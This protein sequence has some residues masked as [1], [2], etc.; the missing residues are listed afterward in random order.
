MMWFRVKQRV[1]RMRYHASKA[2][3]RSYR[4]VL[5]LPK[6]QKLDSDYMLVPKE[7]DD[8]PLGRLVD[9]DKLKD[10]ATNYTT[11]Y[12][13]QPRREFYADKLGRFLFYNAAYD[14]PVAILRNIGH[15]FTKFLLRYAK[16][17]KWQSYHYV[18]RQKEDHI[19]GYI[20]FKVGPFTRSLTLD[21][22]SLKSIGYDADDTFGEDPTKLQYV[23][24]NKYGKWGFST[25]LMVTDDGLIDMSRVPELIER[26]YL[27]KFEWKY[28]HWTS[29]GEKPKIVIE[30]NYTD[31]LCDSCQNH[32]GEEC[33]CKEHGA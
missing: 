9:S 20:T 1:K 32:T 2:Y 29:T 33:E 26:W 6:I 4:W 22:T 11:Y 3:T 23:D 24:I 17:L 21:V 5:R 10:V 25:L 28:R 30:L 16:E 31:E 15:K 13:A 18:D 27:N 8:N 12:H 19:D 7:E 14:W